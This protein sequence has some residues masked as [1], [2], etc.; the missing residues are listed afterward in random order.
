LPFGGTKSGPSALG[1][2]TSPLRMESTI[3]SEAS[4]LASRELLCSIHIACKCGL[5][6]GSESRV[7]AA[8]SI[9][10]R[11]VS[12]NA[13]VCASEIRSSSWESA[14]IAQTRKARRLV[15]LA[16]SDTSGGGMYP[17]TVGG[18]S[19]RSGTQ[20]AQKTDASSADAANFDKQRIGNAISKIFLSRQMSTHKP[21]SIYH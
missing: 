3:S 17:C 4:I 1:L 13:I 5:P 9:A 19:C 21:V 14:R 11:S 15:C 12:A 2:G 20:A 6:R 16:S 7:T 18:R 10:H 8:Y